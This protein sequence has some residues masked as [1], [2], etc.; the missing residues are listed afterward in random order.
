MDA[1]PGSTRGIFLQKNDFLY[2]K[3]PESPLYQNIFP[4]IGGLLTFF[5]IVEGSPPIKTHPYTLEITPSLAPLGGI[6]TP[7]PRPARPMK[8]QISCLYRKIKPPC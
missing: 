7:L 3:F 6:F 5:F 2:R 8:S 4:L 1:L